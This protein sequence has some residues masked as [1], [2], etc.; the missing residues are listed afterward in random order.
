MAMRLKDNQ[1]VVVPRNSR[2]I[3][4]ESDI[5]YHSDGKQMTPR[6]L[7]FDNPPRADRLIIKTVAGVVEVI[8]K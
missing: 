8:W 3:E 6:I 4:T 1:Q 2:F 5:V 7:R